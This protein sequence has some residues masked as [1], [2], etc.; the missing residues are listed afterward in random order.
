MKTFFVGIYRFFGKHKTLFYIVLCATIVALAF[1]SSRLRLDENLTGFFPKSENAETDFVMKNMKAVD[2]IVVIISQRDTVNQDSYTL[3]DAAE[4]YNDSLTARIDTAVQVSLYYDDSATDEI[5][6]YV[7]EQMPLLYTEADFAQLDSLTTDAAL[8]SRMATNRDLMLSPLSTGL[9]QILANDPIGLSTNVLTR[10][11]GISEDSPMTMVDGYIMD[12]QNRNLVMFI[13]LS[14]DFAQTGDNARL[15]SEIRSLAQ[16]VAEACN[17]DFYVYGAPVVA[18]A[19]SERVKADET[20]TLSIAIG[21]ITI[22]I[23]LM[24][25]RKRTIFVIL[26]PVVVGGLFACA[27]VSMLGIELSLISIGA[28]ATVLGVAMSYSIH[29]V[30]HSLHSRS[31]EELI[32]DMAYPMTVGSITTIGAFIGLVFTQSKILH[33]LGLFASLALVGTLLFSLIFLPHFLT[34]EADEKRSFTLR[35]I[36]RISGYDYSRNKILVAVLLI[37]TAVCAFYFTDVRFNSDMT[38]LN[39]QG[40]EWI[41]QSRQVTEHVLEVDGH[42]ATLVVTGRNVDELARNGAALSAKAET[43]HDQGLSRC[44]SLAPAFIVP[45][46]EQQRR[47]ARW[48]NFWTAERKARVVSVLDRE[49]AKNG[50]APNAFDGFKTLIDRQYEPQQLTDADIAE[51][52]LFGEWI[53]K[54][55]ST[56]MLYF[57]ITV[58]VENRDAIMEQLVSERNAVVTDMGYFVRKATSGIVDDFNMILWISSFLVGFVLLLSYGRFELFFMTFLPMCVSW[59]IILGLM[60][61]FGVEFNVVNIILSTFIFGVGD[62]FSIFIMDG[63]QS[64]YNRGKRMLASHKT[65]IALSAFAII[66]GL[67]AQV[68]AQHPAVKSIGLLSI[69]GMVAVIIT[70]YIVQP[71]LFR[72][73]IAKPAIAGLPYT[74]MNVLKSLFF[75]V[76]FL[77]GCVLSNVVLLLVVVLPIGRKRKSRAMHVFVCGFMRLF[78]NLIGLVFKIKKIGKVDFSKPSVII[79]NHTSFIDIIAVLAMSPRIILMTKSWVTS[80]PFFGLLVQYCGFYNVD[81]DNADLIETMRRCVVD[82]YSI[83]VFPE[84]TRSADGQIHR[85]HKGA[86]KIANDLGLDITP[87]IMYGNNHVVSKRQPLLIN[88]GLIVNKVLP[89]IASSSSEYGS[90]YTEQSKLIAAYMRAELQ[91]VTDECGTVDDP[92]YYSAVIRNYTY[93]SPELE[94]YMRIKIR[95]EK[96]YRFFDELIPPAAKICDIGCGYGPLDFMLALHRRQRAIVGIDYDAD[97]IQTAQNSFL[98]RQL[99]AQ[100]SSMRFEAANAAEYDLPESDVFVLNDVLHYMPYETQRTVLERCFAKLNNG[101]MVI[102]RDGNTEKTEKQKVTAL[103]ER[104]S[105]RIFNFNK[106][107]GELCFTNTSTIRGIAAANGFS[108]ETHEKEKRT[109]NT[110]YI[111]R[112][113]T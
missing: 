17:V 70:S 107:E 25:R 73:F 68:F 48:N 32:A 23:L 4:M 77:V 1:F 102:V 71:I 12:V 96:C 47:I 40:D 91:R 18:V 21:I 82:G 53:S 57:N 58:D 79:A 108:C 90:N 109:S 106:T 76:I 35:F 101:G 13:N 36:E 88:T 85:F 46:E 43:L 9:A 44:S 34:P 64:E 61:I 5:I 105:T 16:S 6:S 29:M 69:F 112:R 33:D 20:L 10:L 86:F 26:M 31:I 55:D 100:G 87:V 59:V 103:T 97:K 111:L 15:V 98:C 60:A 11:R 84:G 63:L 3:M 28:G 62:D 8:T 67:G 99:N 52:V 92:Y 45:T 38:K 95:M 7:F 51:S 78:Y 72:C 54:T 27:V 94:W 2:K 89:P 75:Y 37:V 65:A 113:R 14:D 41:E 81:Q 30:T 49:A 110:I 50:F 66:V 22:V 74:L 93:K 24:F 39:Y 19:N 42:R 80:S 83:M 56:Y 104:F